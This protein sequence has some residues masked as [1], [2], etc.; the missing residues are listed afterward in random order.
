MSIGGLDVWV[1]GLNSVVIMLG[2]LDDFVCS[3]FDLL[4]YVVFVGIDLSGI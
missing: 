2:I 1:V 4:G 3:V